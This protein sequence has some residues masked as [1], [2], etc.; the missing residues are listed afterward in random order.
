MFKIPYPR[1]IHI[2]N[3]D[4]RKKFQWGRGENT[5]SVNNTSRNDERQE[6]IYYLGKYESPFQNFITYIDT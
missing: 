1:N 2:K 4:K 3:G 6:H 5:F